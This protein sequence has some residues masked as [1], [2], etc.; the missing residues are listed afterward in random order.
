M[1]STKATMIMMTIEV[2][3]AVACFIGGVLVHQIT[4][5]LVGPR[6]GSLVGGV[7]AGGVLVGFIQS[8]ILVG[9][10]AVA[11]ALAGHI[12]SVWG[13]SRYLSTQQRNTSR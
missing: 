8:S 3:T 2:S 4:R 13:T 11:T 12:G 1:H 7:I 9:G 5:K 6:G 10:I